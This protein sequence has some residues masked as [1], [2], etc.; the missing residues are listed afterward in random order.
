MTGDP[1]KKS[2][3][4]STEFIASNI[5]DGLTA[6][7]Q[8]VVVDGKRPI[9]PKVTLRDSTAPNF[10]DPQA[11]LL[12]FDAALATYEHGFGDGLG[13]VFRSNDPFVG[14]DLD[15]VL[16]DGSPPPV[17]TEILQ[18]LESYTEI[19]VSGNGYH[20]IIEGE[21]PDNWDSRASLQEDYGIEVYDEKRYF[22]LT[23][24]I[25]EKYA[26]ACIYEGQDA[27]EELGEQ[28]L[29]SGA[30]SEAPQE[31]LEEDPTDLT[32]M[33]P[34][35]LT[36]KFDGQ[37]GVQASVDTIKQTLEEYR[38][39][40]THSLSTSAS[41]TIALWESFPSDEIEQERICG[42]S[43]PSSSE[44][45]LHLCKELSFWCRGN[46]SLIAQCWLRSNRGKRDKI[47]RED[48][49]KETITKALRW[50]ETSFEGHYVDV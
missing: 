4:P 20:V 13:F 10:T 26:D 6:R 11:E 21:K 42:N 18:K 38:K 25:V 44:A 9:E 22:K 28:Y 39:V 50:S 29:T 48:Y 31:G 32:A 49:R 41:K 46:Y 5:P 34:A 24:N 7:D 8:W 12:S 45:D 40:N 14:I 19:S 36:A 23:G 33:D 16:A 15:D 30:D 35:D 1:I 47:Q 27:L 17:I 37:E 3:D 43:Y 2:S